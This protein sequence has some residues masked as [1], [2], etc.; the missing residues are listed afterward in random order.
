MIS[1]IGGCLA[2]IA[3]VVLLRAQIDD[4]LSNAENEIFI[5]RS[6]QF[7]SIERDL[8]E[9]E[10][11][12]RDL[13][14]DATLHFV[15]HGQQL[16]AR[17]MIGHEGELLIAKNNTERLSHCLDSIRINF[18]VQ[19]QSKLVLVLSSNHVDYL[20]NTEPPFG[21]EVENAFPKASEEIHEATM[22]L[23]FQRPTAAVFHLMRAMELSVQ[24]LA[25]KLGKTNINEKVW[26]IILSDIDNEIQKMPKG[27]LRDAWSASH[28][29]LYHVKQ[30]WRND[31]MHPKTTYTEEQSK[32]VYE[33][34]K[35]FMR[36]LAPLVS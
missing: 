21:E 6:G 16:L 2:A 36:H 19:M 35:S 10:R 8:A 3:N 25:E 29:H 1:D 31:T 20:R 30:A 9:I 14:L 33:A 24:R 22:C 28:T 26:G 27:S 12:S 4:G 17:G 32:V 13:G 5:I 7:Q 23:M 34:V 11:I 18:L 15:I